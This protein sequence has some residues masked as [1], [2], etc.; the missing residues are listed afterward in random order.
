VYVYLVT[1]K[2]NGKQY[3]GQTIREP[4]KRWYAHCSGYRGKNPHKSIMRDAI[5]KYGKDNFTFE[6]IHTAHSQRELDVMEQFYAYALKTFAP[7]GYN[8]KAGSGRG[9]VS[10]ELKNF[11]SKQRKGTKLSEEHKE[12]L[13]K[14]NTGKKWPDWFR[15]RVSDGKIGK[16]PPQLVYDA[17]S[18]AKAKT[19]ILINPLGE[20]VSI[21][22]LTKFAKEQ[23]IQPKRLFEVIYKKKPSYRGWRIPNVQFP[24]RGKTTKWKITTPAG[25]IIETINMKQ[26]CRENNLNYRSMQAGVR[27]NRQSKQGWK[28]EKCE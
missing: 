22:N 17:L 14:R 24:G 8:L 16:R 21:T 23:G 26:F 19:Y 5:I 2:I 13:R 1:N 6:V 20:T 28:F 4:F 11:W 7:G 25:E 12:K 10:Q 15:K 18:K 3:V 27:Y 9:E